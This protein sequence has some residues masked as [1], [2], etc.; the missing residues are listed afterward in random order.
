LT[1][2]V[3]GVP[4]RFPVT[5]RNEFAMVEVSVI[6]SGSGLSLRITD[7]PGGASTCFD[8]LELEGLC[9]LTPEQRRELVA[10]EPRW[11]D[12]PGERAAERDQAP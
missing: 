12:P 1:G 8:A 3:S 10:P 2:T 7:V 11:S 6:R 9:W 4:D 5:I